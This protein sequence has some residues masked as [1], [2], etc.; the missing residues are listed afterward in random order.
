MIITSVV[1]WCRRKILLARGGEGTKK[2]FYRFINKNG[3]LDCE[4]D[5]L[6]AGCV[7][8]DRLKEVAHGMDTH[9]NEILNN[10][11]SCV[12]TEKKSNVAPSLRKSLIDCY[13]RQHARHEG[14]L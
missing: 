14:I 8:V 9:V 10:T 2:R 3:K 12:A 11:F 1:L 6:V 7:A 5:K 13:W 4:L